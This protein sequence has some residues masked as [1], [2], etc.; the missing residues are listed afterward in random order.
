MILVHFCKEIKRKLALLFAV[1]KGEPKI[2]N[3]A[4]LSAPFCLFYLSNIF[5]NSLIN[6]FTSLNSRYT[7]ANLT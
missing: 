2:A 4:M 3:S 7:D 6:V 5:F 1:K